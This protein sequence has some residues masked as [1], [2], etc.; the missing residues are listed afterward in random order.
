MSNTT[1]FVSNT[2]VAAKTIYPLSV[3][4]CWP[5]G[6]LFIGSQ[7]KNNEKTFLTVY[8]PKAQCTESR[9]NAHPQVFL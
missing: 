9:N 4:L 8:F 1:D 6:F 7:D 2:T 5:A 3:W